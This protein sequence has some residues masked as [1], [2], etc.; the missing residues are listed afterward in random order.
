M[1]LKEDYELVVSMI[2]NVIIKANKLLLDN[3]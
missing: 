3:K 2:D 1:T